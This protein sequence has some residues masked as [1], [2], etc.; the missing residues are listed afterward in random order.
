MTVVTVRHEWKG[1]GGCSGFA[2]L[3]RVFFADSTHTKL[4][5][6]PSDVTNKALKI[7]TKLMCMV[8]YHLPA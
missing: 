7:K 1:F 8:H 5:H 6:Y 3:S 4:Q 2:V